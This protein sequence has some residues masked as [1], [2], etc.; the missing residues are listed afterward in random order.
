VSHYVLVGGAWLGGWCWRPVARL[1]RNRR[2]DVYPATLTGLGERAHLA[3]PQGDL[4]THITD[5]TNLIEF[6]DWSRGDP[7]NI[8]RRWSTGTSWS[9]AE[10]SDEEVLGDG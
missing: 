8:C 1:L 2:H 10:H 4:D 5:V 6:E 9:T 7:K 3:N